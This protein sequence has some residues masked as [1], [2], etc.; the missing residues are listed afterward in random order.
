MALRVWLPLNGNIENQGL[1]DLKF[2]T[3]G[4]PVTQPGKTGN[5]YYFSG[6]STYLKSDNTDVGDFASNYTMSIWIKP[7]T[8]AATG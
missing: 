2:N 3:I 4:T 5:N 6:T 1:S 8:D 7:D